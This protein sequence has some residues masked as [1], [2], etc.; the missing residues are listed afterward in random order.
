MCRPSSSILTNVF[1]I[2]PVYL[3]VLQH[4]HPLSYLFTP[5]NTSWTA[6]LQL[7]GIPRVWQ[8]LCHSWSAEAHLFF[9]C[10]DHPASHTSDIYKAQG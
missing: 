3:V 2:S 7:L 8:I 4:F 10:V 1:E 9:F 5:P 6:E